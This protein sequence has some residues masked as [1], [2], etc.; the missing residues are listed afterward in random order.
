MTS[1]G[2]ARSISVH[3]FNLLHAAMVAFLAGLLRWYGTWVTLSMASVEVVSGGCS[4]WSPFSLIS[5]GNS[6]VM[7]QLVF[8]PEVVIPSK[9]VI[10]LST[11][12]SF[13]LILG[14]SS[15]T[16]NIPNLDLLSILSCCPMIFTKWSKIF[17]SPSLLE[18]MQ[19]SLTDNITHGKDLR[20]AYL[21][22]AC[23]CH[24]NS[25][26]DVLYG[27]TAH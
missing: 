22:R 17:S 12:A 10:S 4:S 11:T 20:V 16:I 1:S 26:K 25:L 3:S 19:Q 2:A 15:W 23:K 21:R 7:G 27:Y 14:I 13:Q 5:S 24:E 18:M 8:P 6:L 9:P